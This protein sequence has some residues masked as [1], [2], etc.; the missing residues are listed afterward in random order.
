MGLLEARSFNVRNPIEKQTLQ[1]SQASAI[2]AKHTAAEVP[3]WLGS[4]TEGATVSRAGRLP[5]PI[6]MVNCTLKIADR[7]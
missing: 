3:E 5:S 1:P 4:D 2:P 7:K 6:R